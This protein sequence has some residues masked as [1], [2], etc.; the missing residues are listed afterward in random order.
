MCS[1]ITA[2]EQ[3]SGK[4]VYERRSRSGEIFSNA[5]ERFVGDLLRAKA[6]KNASGR[7]YRSIGK[8]SFEDDPV[9]HDAFKG[10]LDGLKSL[11]LV[12]HEKGKTRYRRIEE[13]DL[14]VPLRGRA[15]RFWA[16]PKLI[17]L[18]EHHGIH[19]DNAVDHFKPDPPSHP[20]VMRDYATGKG[21]NRQRGPIMKNFPRTEEAKRFEA[22]VRELNEFLGGYRFAGGD[23]YGYTRNFN[24]ADWNK[25]GR[26]Y[27][28][29][30]GYQQLP[31]DKRL[32][33]TINGE[34]VA[35][36]DIKASYLV[37]Y[38][39]CLLGVPLENHVDPYERAGVERSI[40]KS[41]VVHSFGKS[42]P[43]TRWP[44]EAVEDYNKETG[45]D[46]RKVADAKD[47]ASKMLAA[48]PA[49]QELEN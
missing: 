39:A 7:V 25:G 3:Q 48:F 42:R 36:I 33:M 19:K 38:H 27:G 8:T 34:A 5:V 28:V 41:W 4:R 29:G 20:L 24:N 14:S 43:Q 23:H 2:W 1:D 30:G 15:S 26:L 37:I 13:W 32:H 18:A 31:E 12:G 22:D 49:L 46:L 10:M 21:I 47:V 40:A 6:D 17:H 11:S 9:K 35:E 16:T 44:P 45:K